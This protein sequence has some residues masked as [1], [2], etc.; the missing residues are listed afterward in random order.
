MA[1]S[2]LDDIEPFVRPPSEVRPSSNRSATGPFGL[3]GFTADAAPRLRMRRPDEDPTHHLSSNAGF[4]DR[5]GKTLAE[6]P[7]DA[8]LRIGVRLRG[9]PDD[10]PV[11]GDLLDTGHLRRVEQVVGE[12]GVV[13][14]GRRRRSKDAGRLF[15]TGEADGHVDDDDGPTL[16]A[17]PHP[18]D[19]AVAD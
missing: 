15:D 5:L 17:I 16:A 12:D 7:R 10:R 18:D 11:D 1:V 13:L 4:L 6:L 14:Q 9:C 19:L 3:G 2:R 8:P